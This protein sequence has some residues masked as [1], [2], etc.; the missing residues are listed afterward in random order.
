M[1]GL[2]RAL[3]TPRWV[4][5]SLLESQPRALNWELIL[6]H[7]VLWSVFRSSSTV[8]HCW[9]PR[10]IL[11]GCTPNLQQVFH[12]VIYSHWISWNSLW[13]LAVRSCSQHGLYRSYLPVSS[14][15][16][17]NRKLVNLKCYWFMLVMVLQRPAQAYRKTLHIVPYTLVPSPLHS[18]HRAVSNRSR[19]LHYHLHHTVTEGLCPRKVHLPRGA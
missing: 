19:F 8:L 1:T 15:A 14:S 3:N 13:D 2:I 9:V 4:S 18:G 11:R 5:G 17:R 12:P 16:A 7:L 6:G 10:G